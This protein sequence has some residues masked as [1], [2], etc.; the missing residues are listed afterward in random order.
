MTLE[1]GQMCFHELETFG[2]YRL[3][4]TCGEIYAA[5]ASVP[6]LRLLRPRAGVL[7]LWDAWRQAVERTSEGE[8]P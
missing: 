3:C 2:Q 4:R 6:R 8:Q 1:P 5:D 7:A